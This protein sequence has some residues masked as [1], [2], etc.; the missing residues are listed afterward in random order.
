MVDPTGLRY[1]KNTRMLNPAPK[2]VRGGSQNHLKSYLQVSK[3][4]TREEA[5]K[6]GQ[7]LQ[8]YKAVATEWWARTND[9]QWAIPHTFKEAFLSPKA[10]TLLEVAW[11][12]LNS[13]TTWH[14]WKT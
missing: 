2:N 8:T 9:A 5:Y 14:I 3:T 11:L 7:K 13:I 12:T 6:G 4:V 1:Q 10:K